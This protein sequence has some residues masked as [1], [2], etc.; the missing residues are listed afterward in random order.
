MKRQPWETSIFTTYIKFLRT[1]LIAREKKK[2]KK[3]TKRV[4]SLKVRAR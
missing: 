3:T 4:H 2:K 1:V